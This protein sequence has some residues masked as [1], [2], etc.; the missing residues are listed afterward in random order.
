MIK[1][2]T[3]RDYFARESSV[4]RPLFHADIFE[5]NV[6]TG[7]RTS[8][9]VLLTGSTE[10]L[11]KEG[12]RDQRDSEEEAVTSAFLFVMHLNGALAFMLV[13]LPH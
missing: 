2:G 3:E 10:G 11:G 4:S 1:Q 12:R 5:S 9:S 13:K 7:F 6:F 8:D